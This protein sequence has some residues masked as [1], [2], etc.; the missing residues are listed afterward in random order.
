MTAPW[1]DA[2][3]SPGESPDLYEG[4][5]ARRVLAFGIDGALIIAVLLGFGAAATVA[6]IL[7]FG[8][9]SP[10]LAPFYALIPLTYH[11]VTLGGDR[12]ATLGMRVCGLRAV[13]ID[14]GPPSYLLAGL[15]T[16][17]FYL[18]TGLTALLVLGVALFNDRGRTVHDYLCGMLVVNTAA[19][20]TRIQ[21][22]ATSTQTGHRSL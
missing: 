20:A 4:A 3:P 1:I 22:R 19:R 17:L 15:W 8:I 5:L 14:G 11:V 6:G 18:C 12:S 2:P 16:G 21:H 7:S 9:L 13:R 10:A